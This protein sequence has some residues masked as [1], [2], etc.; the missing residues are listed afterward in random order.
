MMHKNVGYMIKCKEN[1]L[2][3]PEFITKWYKPITSVVKKNFQTK[4]KIEKLFHKMACFSIKT[5]CSA[6]NCRPKCGQCVSCEAGVILLYL[7]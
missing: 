7:L 4:C 2:Y 5:V 3:S 1:S 6:Q